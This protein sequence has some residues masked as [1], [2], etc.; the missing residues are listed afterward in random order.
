VLHVGASHAFGGTTSALDALVKIVPATE[1]FGDQVLPFAGLLAAARSAGWRIIHVSV[2]S[3]LEWDDFESTY[4]A[5]R[6]EW[7]LAH[8]GD[9]RAADIRPAARKSW[10]QVL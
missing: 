3:Q 2:A 1:L 4:R 10:S 5:G 6:Q 9:P 8:A 7:L